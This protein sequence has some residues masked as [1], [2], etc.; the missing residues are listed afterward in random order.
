MMNDA[1]VRKWCITAIDSLVREVSNAFEGK[2]FAHANL[3]DLSKAFDC[4]DYNKLVS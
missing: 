4:V 3:C 1:L 2:A